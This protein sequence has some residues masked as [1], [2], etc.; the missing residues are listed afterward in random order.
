M[1][2]AVWTEGGAA[3]ARAG[4]ATTTT[5]LQD[6]LVAR[7]APYM[8]PEQA[9]GEA[10]DYRTDIFSLGVVLFEMLTGRVP[11]LASAATE[12]T[13]EAVHGPLIPPTTL[14]KSLPAEIDT[15]VERMLAKNP[16]E[17]YESAA[18]AAAELRAVSKILESRPAPP[19]PAPARASRRSSK[20]GW[21]AVV[22]AL[23]AIAVLIWFATQF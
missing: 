18:T 13:Q 5:A 21:I 12:V 9:L 17:R 8:S 20:A 19:P 2:L 23:A 10:V 3:R 6:G 22:A 7:T 4:L 16:A 1:G 14:N 11:F 15:I